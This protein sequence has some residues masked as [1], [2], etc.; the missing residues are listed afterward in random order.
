M[1]QENISLRKALTDGVNGLNSKVDGNAASLQGQIKD[2]N[3]KLTHVNDNINEKLDTMTER[4]LEIK[5]MIKAQIDD[6]SGF[7]EVDIDAGDGDDPSL[8]GGVG[9]IQATEPN[10]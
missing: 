3:S 1:R 2:L 8:D 4:F 7:E 9:I 6:E 5:E 10:K